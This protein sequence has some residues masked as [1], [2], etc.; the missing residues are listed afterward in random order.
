MHSI[1]FPPMVRA[2]LLVRLAECERRLASACDERLQLAALCGAFQLAR[3]EALK[4][5]A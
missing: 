1:E 2:E 4:L 5:A 3:D